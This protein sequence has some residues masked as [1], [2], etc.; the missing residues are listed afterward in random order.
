MAVLA[1]PSTTANSMMKRMDSN[2]SMMLWAS[3][4]WPILGRIQTHL[5]LLGKLY[6]EARLCDELAGFAG[7]I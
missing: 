6:Y 4:Q 1:I 3:S 7:N 5:R 2:S